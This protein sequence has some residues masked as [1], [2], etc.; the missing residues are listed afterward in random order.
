[1]PIHIV[2]NDITR[3]SCDAIVNAANPKLRR[4][5]GGVDAAIHKAAGP[6]LARECQKLGGC[7]PGQAKITG[8]YHLPCRYV[9]HTAGPHWLAL[10]AKKKE[11]LGSCYREALKLA[12]E[13]HCESIAFPLIAT[14]ALG[15]PRDQA[16][17]I[18]MSEI[19]RFLLEQEMTVYLVV[20]DKDSF[21]ISKRLIDDI[22]EY[23]D[24]YYVE[25]HVYG[26][27]TVLSTYTIERPGPL[28]MSRA[29][30]WND[31]A[32]VFNL[33]LDD[34]L[35]ELDESF[36]EML[37]RK[38]DESGMTDAQVYKKANV[39]RKLFSKIRSNVHYR[40]SKNT[41]IAFAIA[42]RLPLDETKDLLMK[43]GFA[44]SHSNKTDIIIE[45]FIRKGNY[46]IFEINEA[47]FAFDQS[48]LGM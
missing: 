35:N 10:P 47:L 20:Y 29:R 31:E 33:K 41:V 39:D 48:L 37:L 22:S 43:A 3:M 40:P 6:E 21:Q 26:D 28:G 9:I 5:G 24:E 1:M 38:I 36:S 18:A 42:L 12:L 8:A 2:R 44:L 16:F 30:E 11:I 19:S 23:I 25:A 17:Q 14:G 32:P 46:D 34:M 13:Y 7:K 15:F 45:Y 27:S 4:G